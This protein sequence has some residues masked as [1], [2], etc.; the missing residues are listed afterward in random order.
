MKSSSFIL[1]VVTTTMYYVGSGSSLS[2]TFISYSKPD[3]ISNRPGASP[4]NLI[5]HRREFAGHERDCSLFF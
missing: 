2:R 1:S 4:K 5:R 3:Q